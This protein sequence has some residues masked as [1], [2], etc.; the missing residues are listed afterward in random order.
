MQKDEVAQKKRELQE[1]KFS[2]SQRYSKI[3]AL[4][5]R[6]SALESSF[7]EVEVLK[8]KALLG[9]VRPD[10]SKVRSVLR[11]EQKQK[12]NITLNCP[13]QTQGNENKAKTNPKLIE[14]ERAGPDF[15]STAHAPF[16]N[17]DQ[18]FDHQQP[19]QNGKVGSFSGSYNF[20]ITETG[21]MAIC[22]FNQ[23]H[24]KFLAGTQSR[25]KTAKHN[26]TKALRKSDMVFHHSSESY[27]ALATR[28]SKHIK[29]SEN[30]RHRM[31][32]SSEEY[33]MLRTEQV[34]TEVETTA[35]KLSLDKLEIQQKAIFRGKIRHLIQA[36]S[37]ISSTKCPITDVLIR[38]LLKKHEIKAITDETH[39]DRF[40]PDP[41]EGSVFPKSNPKACSHKNQYR[42][43]LS[44]VYGYRG[45]DCTG[46]LLR[47]RDG[48]VLYYVGS[49]AVLSSL[50]TNAQHVF[51]GHG[52]Q[53]ITCMALHPDGLT[54]A[55]GSCGNGDR[56]RQGLVIIWTRRQDSVCQIASLHAERI[57]TV[58]FLA[59]SKDG[60]RVVAVG[61]VWPCVW[62]EV[63]EW[64]TSTKA[65]AAAMLGT[66]HVTAIVCNPFNDAVVACGVGMLK[67]WRP[68]AVEVEKFRYFLGLFR[69]KLLKEKSQI[70]QQN[71][72]LITM[73]LTYLPFIKHTFET[74]SK[75]F[76]GCQLDSAKAEAD[77]GIACCHQTQALFDDLVDHDHAGG[78]LGTPFASLVDHKAQLELARELQYLK[79]RLQDLSDRCLQYDGYEAF[80]SRDIVDKE[81]ASILLEIRLS[82]EELNSEI[83]GKLKSVSGIH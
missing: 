64:A 25:L 72:L 15:D 18:R 42:L 67:I 46:N 53:Q 33:Q 27:R 1:F 68:V 70:T 16:R 60:K 10:S 26:L 22:G 73:Q 5:A 71:N 13:V 14:F 81:I 51:N 29:Y 36:W 11:S 58:D 45:R 4:K 83:Q 8:A 66:D 75:L 38:R 43:K 62:M 65:I 28:L 48:E 34:S 52:N 6:S 35:L 17:L 23:V 21:S 40:A 44:H 37:S 31:N 20:S 24:L 61:G 63:Y 54:V 30:V 69:W 80:F 3:K 47:N 77:C 56:R 7:K 12:S 39:A 50:T 79:K 74:A 78:E 9:L 82:Y 19:P 55:T 59:F 49:L 2:V 41:W 57:E 76:A 32:L